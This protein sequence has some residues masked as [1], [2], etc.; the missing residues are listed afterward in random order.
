MKL[1]LK[2][3]ILFLPSILSA[4]SITYTTGPNLSNK[5]RSHQSQLL[6]NGKV[7]IMGGN[8]AV[9]ANITSYNSCELY[10]P[11]TNSFEPAAPMSIA[12][13]SLM[14]EILNNGNVIAMGG[15]DDK[16]VFR[17]CEIYNYQTN[18]WSMADSMEIEHGESTSI[19][20]RDGRLLVAGGNTQKCEIYDPEKNTWTY[21]GEMKNFH[22]AGMTLTMLNNGNI[23]AIGG[24]TANNSIE[25]FYPTTGTWSDAGTTKDKRQY[26]SA[27]LLNN[28]NILI[29]GSNIN[30]LTSEIYDVYYRTTGL[31]RNLV[32]NSAGGSMVMLDNGNILLFTIG[33]F[34]TPE[35]PKTFQEYIP[36]SNT[37]V[38]S[39]V[40]KFFIGTNGYSI[41][42]L[43]NGTFFIAGGNVNTGSGAQKNTYI[44]NQNDNC[45]EPNLNSTVSIGKI[46]DCAGKNQ[47][48]TIDQPDA[49]T[50]YRF[51][52]GNLLL[53]ST[54]APATGS[55]SYSISGSNLNIGKNIITIKVIKQGCPEKAL[56]SSALIQVDDTNP[57]IPQIAVISGNN[58]I[59]TD[60][61]SSTLAV[62]NHVSGT[63]K[64]SNLGAGI[65]NPISG[66]VVISVKNVDANGCL[67][68]SSNV[69]EIQKITSDN[70]KAGAD[71]VICET[72]L[73]LIKL[74][75]KPTGGTW[76]GTG[77]VNNSHFDP[78]VSGPGSFKLSY[79]FCNYVSDKYIYVQ[80]SNTV[81]IDTNT[82]TWGPTDNTMC[83]VSYYT[84]K[85]PK[86]NSNKEYS[87]NFIVDNTMNT[88]ATG[89]SFSQQYYFGSLVPQQKTAFIITTKNHSPA[90]PVDTI[91]ISKTFP[92]MQ[93]PSTNVSSIIPDT[94]CYGTSGKC[95]ILKPQK[96][97]LY[98]A[99][100]NQNVGSS[101]STTNENDTLVLDVPA[102]TND[103]TSGT[104]Y[105][106]ASLPA[107]CQKNSRVSIQY[108][109]VYGISP[110]TSF[111]LTGVYNTGQYIAAE[112]KTTADSLQL[113]IDGT[114]LENVTKFEPVRYDTEGTHNYR[115]TGFSK[116]GCSKSETKSF[117]VLKKPAMAAN[118]VCSF[119]S[120]GFTG[121][122][123][124]TIVDKKGNIIHIGYKYTPLGCSYDGTF[125]AYIK[126]IDKNTPSANWEIK[127]SFY[128]NN[129]NSTERTCQMF[130]TGVTYDDNN[131]IYITGNYAGSKLTLGQLSV[132]N[133]DASSVRPHVFVAKINELG[134]VEWLISDDDISN[135]GQY[136]ASRGVD[137]QYNN[138]NLYFSAKNAR[139][140]WKNH[141]GQNVP[142]TGI[143]GYDCYRI[144]QI[145]KSG[146]EINTISYIKTRN[147]TD[148]FFP[149]PTEM[150]DR[151][152]VGTF[153][154][155]QVLNNNEI[156]ICGKLNSGNSNIIFG[157]LTLEEYTGPEF[158]AILNI[159]QKEFT[160][161]KLEKSM[162]GVANA[163]VLKNRDKISGLSGKVNGQISV[164]ED[165]SVSL[166]STLPYS[167]VKKVNAN[168]DLL[169]KKVIDGADIAEVILSADE[170]QVI[171]TGVSTAGIKFDGTDSLYG[172]NIGNGT[173]KDQVYAI[174]ID[175][176]QGSVLW[177]E[178]MGST[179]LSDVFQS[180]AISNC[181]D[182]IITGGPEYVNYDLGKVIFRE[183][184][185]TTN[186]SYTVRLPLSGNCNK[187]DCAM[188]TEIKS[189]A[190]S[191]QFSLYPNPANNEINISNTHNLIIKQIRV[192]DI[193]G[194]FVLSPDL[195]YTDTNYK[196]D[197]SVLNS[198]LYIIEIITED[199]TF[200]YKL[201]KN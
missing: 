134:T 97:V 147:V 121:K 91:K 41:N 57:F 184:T 162:S 49:N 27:I 80:P 104:V 26:H 108:K 135:P 179:I 150:D 180:S 129:Y 111:E 175:V 199:K 116:Y 125:D 101:V 17:S 37:W 65:Q 44:V 127:H 100:H 81:D 196:L 148:A 158:T 83:I 183:D 3:L 159:S 119:D 166:N 61:A 90:C 189:V 182:L 94:I 69:V 115:V 172:I 46:S 110:V 176:N 48:I 122:I 155:L 50:T 102:F 38:S 2:L 71:N 93:I 195:N 24:E 23:I 11:T 63:Y 7:L 138:G 42:K 16:S 28:G 144:F 117:I 82:I 107:P 173:Y 136:D 149:K 86:G 190:I 60:G 124:K 47:T 174:G 35:D 114:V 70:V 112:I 187:T 15:V 177:A 88:T 51:Y 76:S 152:K 146:S 64:W 164:T 34:F 126:K 106:F 123:Y 181:N 56:Q 96:N 128:G 20:L 120:I 193:N 9:Y 53:G 72:N 169:W 54:V 68:K 45:T 66:S 153:P 33:D 197:L 13:G 25:I 165:V 188:L 75:G 178:Q 73:N 186:N 131:D 5:S 55:L 84:A 167:V 32:S 39:G 192:K 30:Q 6:P 198:S 62:Q 19:K 113:A 140:I 52:A 40:F 92:V 89:T 95:I 141:L 170:S 139:P 12:K 4:Q 98:Y 18:T 130:I 103:N 79:T 85:I 109:S 74:E 1:Y 43:N 22:G 59:C 31:I 99:E 160:S 67:S 171:I 14:S 201:I 154:K 157:N 194:K 87:Y 21:A 200:N 142:I 10:N 168:G 8:D 118:T 163:V 36:S 77:I 156:A 185:I 161:A 78:A 137:I 29:A 145:N 143:Y 191:Q 132:T 133:I 151:R 105:V 58:Y